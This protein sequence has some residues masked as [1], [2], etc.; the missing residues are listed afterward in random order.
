[1][2]EGDY[3]SGS[4]CAG[5]LEGF[6]PHEDKI[7]LVFKTTESISHV[8]APERKCVGFDEYPQQIT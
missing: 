8:V 1:V 7:G 5:Q 4:F 3:I 2:F 6:P